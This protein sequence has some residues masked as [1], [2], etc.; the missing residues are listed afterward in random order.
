[1]LPQRK[2]ILSP[3]RDPVEYNP[4]SVQSIDSGIDSVAGMYL[5][6]NNN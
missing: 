5:K 6:V 4:M 1:M 2:N 3:P